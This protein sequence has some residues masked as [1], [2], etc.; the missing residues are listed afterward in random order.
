MSTLSHEVFTIY[1]SRIRKNLFDSANDKDTRLRI[2]APT[3]HSSGLI[4]NL[5]SVVCSGLHAPHVLAAPYSQ[6]YGPSV[7]LKG[8]LL[9]RGPFQIERS[10]LN[11]ASL[12][13]QTSGRAAETS[14]HR[15]SSFHPER[16]PERVGPRHPMHTCIGLACNPRSTCCYA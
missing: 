2:S 3:F 6:R 15:S 10:L 14:K 1:A 16:G 13:A 11:G 9:A 5:P 7:D 8:P 12:R 4:A